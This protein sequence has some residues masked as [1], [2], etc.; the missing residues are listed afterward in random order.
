MKKGDIT[1]LRNLKEGDKFYFCDQNGRIKKTS[2]AYY[3]EGQYPKFKC[4]T[5][6]AE[7]N[8]L[9]SF[10]G[11]SIVPCEYVTGVENNQYVKVDDLH[12]LHVKHTLGYGDDEYDY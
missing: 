8:I 12:V 1:L 7:M 10:T 6:F 3:V 9:H 4:T 11:P 5:V 2:T